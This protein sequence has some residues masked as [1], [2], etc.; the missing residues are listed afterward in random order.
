MDNHNVKNHMVKTEISE[1]QVDDESD[2]KVTLEL[3]PQDFTQ[4]NS[5]PKS[6]DP[7]NIIGKYNFPNLSILQ[8]SVE[9]TEFF[10]YLTN[11][12]R[13]QRPQTPIWICLWFW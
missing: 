9:I 12:Q 3:N 13:P 10:G 4:P 6:E 7:E 1:E 5:S 11:P 2:T 8:Y